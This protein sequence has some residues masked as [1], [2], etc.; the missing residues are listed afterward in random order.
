[1]IRGLRIIVFAAALVPL[2][3]GPLARAGPGARGRPGVREG[4]QAGAAFDRHADRKM[5]T[6]G[7]STR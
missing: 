1:M 4:I 2:A 6:S 5:T 7:T 3:I